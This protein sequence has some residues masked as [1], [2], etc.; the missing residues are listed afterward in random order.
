MNARVEKT[1]W[2]RDYQAGDAAGV[3][4]LFRAVYGDYYV[5]PDVYLP[6]Q[7]ERRNRS[8]Q[9]LS[10]V[11]LR[12]DQLVGHAALWRDPARPG[13]AELALNAVHPDARGLGI[14]TLLGRHLI[15]AAKGLG[16]ALITIKQVCSHPQSQYVA[17]SLGFHTTAL[18]LDYVASPFG[19]PEPESIVL[20][21]LPLRARALP[22]LDWPAA[23]RDWLR[24]LVQ[25][26]GENA[27]PS[28]AQLPSELSLARH[29]QRLEIHLDSPSAA[30]IDEI[31]ALP[32]NQ[33]LYLTL[34]LSAEALSLADAL[35]SHGFRFC[36]LLP[37]ARLG[38]RLLWLRGQGPSPEHF[39]DARAEQ[40]CE[41][42]ETALTAGK[43]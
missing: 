20:G 41:L 4:A 22:A 21:C 35:A 27:A 30:R 6:S 23:W 32:A 42:G 19:K 38:W 12:G 37:D 11:A 31:A 7:I 39:C 14:A 28:A 5:Y 29:G 17:Q 18:L 33:L 1:A 10:A 43:A 2:A 16:L 24:P 15:D 36:G 25:T 3:S 40:L 13:Q 8:G 9:W 26:F 34:A